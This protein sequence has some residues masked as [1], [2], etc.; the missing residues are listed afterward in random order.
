MNTSHERPMYEFVANLAGL[1]DNSRY[2]DLKGRVVADLGVGDL[3]L[4]D[5]LL[6]SGAES[7]IVTGMP[8]LRPADER[9][10]RFDGDPLDSALPSLVD[11]A[12][13][14]AR[15]CPSFD[16]VTG[17]TRLVAQMRRSIKSGGTVFAILKTGIVIGGFDVHNSIV[18]GASE[19]LPSNDY[20]FRD[21]LSDCTVRTLSWIPSSNQSEHVRLMRL[22]L[23][24][25]SL[26]LILGRSH[27]GK[28]SLAR[29]FLALDQSMH[30]SN[31]YIYTELVQRSRAGQSTA[32]PKALVEAAG[33]GSG[34]ACG[35]FNRALE[36]DP[37]L[38]RQ[39]M[40]WII[41]LL[42][43]NKRAIS[44]DFDLVADSQ[45]DVVKAILTQ[46]GYSVWIVR[47]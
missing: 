32:F 24:R 21:L 19:V 2:G 45:V 16:H 43:Q 46:A 42:P 36:S 17:I 31:D 40:S 44:M 22:T 7:V 15:C 4:H 27:S 41:P 23:K 18:R 12:F 5:A 28:T 8:E 37:E 38:L 20:L 33:D 3:R 1:A 39:Y 30:V 26:L 6:L 9:I 34:K 13:I 25:P 14:D 11:V 47:R 29:D 35:A 10:A